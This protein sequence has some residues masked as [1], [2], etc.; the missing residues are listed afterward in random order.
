MSRLSTTLT[1]D[2]IGQIAQKDDLHVAPL[3]ADKRTYGT[4]TWIW[5]VSVGNQLFV[6]AY[7][8][9]DSRWYQSALS[10]KEGKIEAAGMVKHVRFEPVEGIIHTKIDDAYRQKYGGSPYLNAMT[11]SRARAAT[12][13]IVP[14]N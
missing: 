14:G 4:P 6:R 11:S 7:N 12:I 2:E 1:P 9:T 3:R 5:S 13:Q 10:Q 8:G